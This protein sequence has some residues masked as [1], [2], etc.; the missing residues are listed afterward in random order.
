MAQG[1]AH[2]FPA[3]AFERDRA[4]EPIEEIA[5]DCEDENE[6]QVPARVAQHRIGTVAARFQECQG[7]RN[8][9]A[10]CGLT[11]DWKPRD[12]HPADSPSE[13]IPERS[14]DNPSPG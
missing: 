7:G 14:G 6:N 9:S 3:E 4:A 12:P 13:T 11:P 1:C 10:S 5:E 2:H 8:E